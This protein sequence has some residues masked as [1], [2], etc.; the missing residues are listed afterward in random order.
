M[1]PEQAQRLL[2]A[3]LISQDVYNRNFNEAPVMSPAPVDSGYAPAV[4]EAPVESAAPVADMVPASETPQDPYGAAISA[5][6]SSLKDKLSSV[7][8]SVSSRGAL[9]PAE[10]PTVASA[11]AV[12]SSAPV[13]DSTPVLRLTEQDISSRLNEQAAQQAKADA[14]AE[15]ASSNAIQSA[16]NTQLA[17]ANKIKNETLG[18]IKEEDQIRRTAEADMAKIDEQRNSQRAEVQNQIDSEF[19]AVKERFDALENEK[20]DPDKF[21]KD[22][23]SWGSVRSILAIALGGIGQ[24]LAGGENKALQIIDKQIERDINAQEKNIDLKKSRANSSLNLFQ[25]YQNIMK[26]KEDARDATKLEYLQRYKMSIENMASRYKKPEVEQNFLNFKN[27]LDAQM[28]ATRA[29]LEESRQRKA[30]NR[31]LSGNTGSV[32]DEKIQ[33][34]IDELQQSPE[35]ADRE[36]ANDLRDR[37]IPGLGISPASKETVTEFR[38]YKQEVQ[39]AIEGAKRILQFTNSGEFSRLS[40]NDRARVAT[41]LKALVGQLRLPFTGPGAMTDTTST[42]SSGSNCARPAFRASATDASGTSTN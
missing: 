28:A 13:A 11:E 20:V 2:Q 23:G 25:N 15:A 17:G 26:N 31:V 8:D 24:S 40:P 10:T 21:W 19:T 22:Q 41:E 30:T 18:L 6:G 12:D 16:Y 36:R 34:A 1:S 33:S 39:P 14:A 32:Q 35:K 37:Y 4:S 27:Q 42:T 5:L 7:Y 29:K 38:K 3:G 9:A